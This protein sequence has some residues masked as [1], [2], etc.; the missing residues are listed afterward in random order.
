MVVQQE[1]TTKEALEAMKLIMDTY[2]PSFTGATEEEYDF[3]LVKILIGIYDPRTGTIPDISVPLSEEDSK[4]L[5]EITR[6]AHKDTIA[7]LEKLR[8][9]VF[10]K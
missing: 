7:M 3:M 9:A 4:A 2:K 1:L 10:N 8:A 5:W 6:A